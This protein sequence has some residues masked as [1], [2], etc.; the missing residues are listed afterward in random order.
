MDVFVVDFF[1]TAI[2]HDVFQRR[3]KKPSLR[4]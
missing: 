4:G 3:I 2:G 1:V